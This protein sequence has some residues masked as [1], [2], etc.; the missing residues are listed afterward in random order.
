[1]LPKRE[2]FKM[3]SLFAYQDALSRDC[4]GVVSVSLQKLA[5]G[6]RRGRN[7]PNQYFR[8]LIDQVTCQ[9]CLQYRF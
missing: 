8:P 7:A 3:V 2:Y 1:M 6:N 5:V 9:G 4:K